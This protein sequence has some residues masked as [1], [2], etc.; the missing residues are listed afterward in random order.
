MTSNK[1]QGIN[2]SRR[3]NEEDEDMMAQENF[4]S[5]SV[6]TKQSVLISV[7]IDEGI[8][9]A[10]YYRN[11]CRAIS[12]TSKGDQIEFEISSP[13]GLLDGL[14]A[15]LTALEK[16]EAISVA[17][18]N[19]E[20]HSAASMLAL[21]CDVVYVSPYATMLVHFVRFGSSGKATD[22]VTHTKHVF[23]TSKELF[24]ETYKYF[25]SDSEIERCVDGFELYLNADEIQERL[26][27]KFEALDKEA[28]KLEKEMKK[29]I[30]SQS[31][32]EI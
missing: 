32:G 29:A 25:L 10:A 22:V 12:D 31:Q 16:T 3:R 13:G 6:K 4:L 27:R 24:E 26:K 5:Y 23:D 21:N 18:I 7:P 30:K 20:C 15:L 1:Y 17:H 11:V 8:K 14:T 28:K 2:N 9:G 19:G